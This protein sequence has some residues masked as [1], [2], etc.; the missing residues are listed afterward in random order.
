MRTPIL[1]ALCLLLPVSASRASPRY[2]DEEVLRLME[3]VQAEKEPESRRAKACRELEHTEARLHLPL[4]RRILREDRSVDVRLCAAVTLVAHGDRKSPRDTL[5][6]TAYEGSRTPNCSRSD[7]LIALGR[8]GDPAGTMH[9]ERALKGVAPDDEPYFLNDACRALALLNTPE[10]LRLLSAS[11][12]DAQSPSLRHAAVSPMATLAAGSA[13]ARRKAIADALVRAAR[14]D[15][16]DRV[17]EQAGSALFWSGV[18]GPAFFRLLSTDPS[19]AV[20]SRMVRVLARNY[21]SP[22]RL[23]RVEALMAKEKDPAVREEWARARAAQSPP[24][25]AGQ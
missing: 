12:R 11:L 21:L 10:A 22:A 13:G 2:G 17:G 8:L 16:E 20:R 24:T 15:P 5:L 23:S 18:D 1:I 14:T 3:I 7:V 9:I 4:L 19:P 6:A 25:P